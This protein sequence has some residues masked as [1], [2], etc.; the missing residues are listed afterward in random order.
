MP[1]YRERRPIRL[2][3]QAQPAPGYVDSSALL[4]DSEDE[5]IQS[6]GE[7]SEDDDKND[8]H[9][10]GEDRPVTKK[11]RLKGK[12]KARAKELSRP[13]PDSSCLAYYPETYEAVRSWNQH[14]NLPPPHPMSDASTNKAPELILHMPVLPVLIPDGSRTV[15][16]RGFIKKNESYDETKAGFEKL[17]GEIRSRCFL[18]PCSVAYCYVIPHPTRWQVQSLWF[19][20]RSSINF[21][22][23]FHRSI[24]LLY[25]EVLIARLPRR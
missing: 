10:D 12:F 2:A 1:S 4:F 16:P 24:H 3:K 13:L 25:E 17:P 11:P 6:E 15:R 8:H 5:G 9:D 18:L 22:N 21:S 14:L 19:S 20:P 7:C 23:R